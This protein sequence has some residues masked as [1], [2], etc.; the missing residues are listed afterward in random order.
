MGTHRDGTW[1]EKVVPLCEL[2]AALRG[3]SD[4]V[5]LAQH[6][7]FEQLPA[8][9]DD[10]RV[11]DCVGSRLTRT[12]AWL[13]SRNTVTP[14]HFDSYDGAAARAPCAS[15]GACVTHAARRAAG[16][17]TQ[18]CGYKYVRLYAPSQGAFLYRSTAPWESQRRWPTAETEPAAPDGAVPQGTISLVDVEK[19]DLERFPLFAQASFV[20]TVLVSAAAAA[21]LQRD[22]PRQPSAL[23]P[24]LRP[25]LCACAQAP[26]DAL[27]IPAGCWHFVKSLSV[28]ASI[29]FVF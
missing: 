21:L 11:P 14:L 3:D 1:H 4:I 7:L 2:V 27:F 12:N 19:P 22:P 15:C 8:L 28:S 5:Y 25:L 17:L 24:R 20:E 9:R 29:S 13:G 23:M 26:G 16:L 18:V 6:P 10:Y